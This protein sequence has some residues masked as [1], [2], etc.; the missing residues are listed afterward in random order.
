MSSASAPRRYGRNAGKAEGLG[1]TAAGTADKS[2]SAAAAARQRVSSSSVAADGEWHAAAPPKH[3]HYSHHREQQQQQQQQRSSPPTSHIPRKSLSDF[4]TTSIESSFN[5]DDDD[6]TERA[7]IAV[8]DTLTVRTRSPTKGAAGS[9]HTY[10]KR[11]RDSQRGSIGGGGGGGSSSEATAYGRPASRRRDKESAL[12]VSEC[13][14]STQL[15]DCWVSPCESL[16]LFYWDSFSRAVHGFSDA[17]PHNGLLRCL[18]L[19]KLV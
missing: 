10:N 14:C 2:L 12:G 13:P 16:S 1:L 18:L 11:P 6:R 9:S 8:L 15:R 7:T 3:H 19:A 4:R 5:E 17:E